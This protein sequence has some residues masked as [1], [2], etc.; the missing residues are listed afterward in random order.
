MKTSRRQFLKSASAA[1]LFTILPSGI[2]AQ[3]GPRISPNSKIRIACIGVGGRGGAAVGASSR[4]EIVALCDVDSK[5]A[6]GAFNK[7]KKAKQF[8]DYREMFDKMGDQ[9]D[10]VTI[11]GPDHVHFVHAMEAIKRGKHVYVE[12]PLCQTIEQTRLLQAAAK[13]AGVKTQMGN[14]GHSK[15]GI[16]DF[17]EMVDAGLIGDI[18]E[19]HAW[20]NRPAGWWPQ[21][22]QELPAPM[23]APP[24]LDWDLWRNGVDT[25]FSTE[26]VP[27][28]WRGWTMWGTGALGDMACHILDPTF[29]ALELGMPDWIHAEAEGGSDVS[30]PNKS[31]VK[32]HFPARK[33]RDE[34]ILTWFDGKG[35]LPPRP[36]MLEEGRKM[37]NPSG[38][39]ITYGSKETV[40]TDSHAANVKIIP[41]LR[42]KELKAPEQTLR[43]V[44]K[45]DHFGDW[46]RAIRGEV[47]QASSHFDYAGELNELVLLGSIAQRL[48]G[49]KL[50][51]DTAKGTFKNSEVGNKLIKTALI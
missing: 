19:I 30:F 5:M 51:W 23:E 42:A 31:T 16:R 40:M 21:G 9:I 10:A 4:E 24:T 47:E 29:Y 45:E 34:I 1:S 7:F 36:D 41:E 15:N 37:G 13:K 32:F 48:P 22:K 20:T 11:S 38:G 35:N 44:A 46:F 8:T 27:F 49:Q 50:E 33:G 18:K 17:K 14:Q 28:K 26:Y 2:Y 25:P 43:R 12:K 39:S 3:N 6:A